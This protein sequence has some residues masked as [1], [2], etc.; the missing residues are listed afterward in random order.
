MMVWLSEN[1]GTLLISLVLLLIV[2]AIIIGMVK[3][4]QKG[5]LACNAHCLHCP[6]GAYCHKHR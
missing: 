1:K 6:M 4:R 5:K 2:A 3:D